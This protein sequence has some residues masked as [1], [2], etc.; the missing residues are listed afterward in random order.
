MKAKRF[1]LNIII[2]SENYRNLRFDDS[3]GCFR[4]CLFVLPAL[5]VRIA[6]VSTQK[7]SLNH[8]MEMIRMI[9]NFTHRS[10]GGIGESW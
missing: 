4:F 9:C 6:Q 5:P 8:C 7:A 1:E 3:G 10:M 2:S